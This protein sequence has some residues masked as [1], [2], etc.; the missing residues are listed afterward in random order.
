MF[1]AVETSRQ[2]DPALEIAFHNFE[3]AFSS[4]YG[5]MG[6]TGAL[7]AYLRKNVSMH[8]FGADVGSAEHSRVQ[9]LAVFADAVAKAKQDMPTIGSRLVSTTEYKATVDVR[10]AWV[11]GQ[12]V[13]HYKSSGFKT[14]ME[15]GQGQLKNVGHFFGR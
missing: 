15:Q 6:G 14:A 1:A 2:D 13:I 4:A 10:S 3:E 5:S 12:Q 7:K 8:G 11:S 9:A